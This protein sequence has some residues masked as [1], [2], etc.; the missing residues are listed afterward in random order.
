MKKL[1]PIFL[2]AGLLAGAIFLFGFLN[3]SAK[4]K[5]ALKTINSEE[6]IPD[7]RALYNALREHGKMLLVHAFDQE[8]DKELLQQLAKR[9]SYQRRARL[10]VVLVNEK[11]LSATDLTDNPIYYIGNHKDSPTLKRIASKLPINFSQDGFQFDNKDYH[12]SNTIFKLSLIPNP[13]NNRFPFYLITGNSNEAI[14]NYLSKT[15]SENGNSFSRNRWNYEVIADNQQLVFGNLNEQDWSLDKKTHFDFS[16]GHLVNVES[17]HFSLTSFCPRWNR[18]RLNRLL[19]N[20][21]ETLENIVAF[22]GKSAE[23]I[24]VQY[25]IFPNVENKGLRINN[26][27]Q[28]N[29]DFENNHVY[30]VANDNFSG[31]FL[32]MENELIIRKLM[33]Q[34]KQLALEKGFAVYFTKNWQ[35]EGFQYWAQRLFQ[36]QNLPPLKELMNNKL[37]REESDLVISCSAGMLVQ[38]LIEEWGKEKFIKKYATWIPEDKE[39]KSLEKAWIKYLKKLPQQTALTRNKDLPYLKGFNF[40]H[41]GY[42][43]YNG[44]GSQL[45]NESLTRLQKIGS[46]AV[47]IVPY[48]YMNSPNKPSF[49]PITESAGSENDEAVIFAHTRAQNLGMQTILKPQIWF[50]RGSWPGDVSMNSE[51]DWQAFFENYYRWMRHYAL[52]AEMYDFDALC[53]GVEFAKATLA[54]EAD[55]RALIKKLKGIYSGPVTYAANWGDEFENIKFWDALDYIGIDCYYPLSDQDTPSKAELDKNF[56]KV[57]AKIEK[58]SLKFQKPVIFT[59]IGFRSVDQTWL[60]PHEDARNRA[61]NEEAQKMCYEVVFENIKGKAWCNGLLWWKWPSYLDNRGK[62]NTRFTPYAKATEQTVEQW[63]AKLE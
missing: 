8:K 39:V 21:Q 5:V 4:P 53:I 55:W 44:Y 48:S 58:V 52:V 16:T 6:E 62:E 10:D 33:G 26:S 50:G 57:I 60:N 24:K 40:A 2:M 38:F 29:C 17:E 13:E 37:L 45:A 56:K 36:S 11:S 41:E 59:E 46:N 9:M 1:L 30:V 32:Q 28:A 54:R 35:E 3:A 14:I 19:M 15:L 51:A 31:H 23:G 18:N 63:F 34:P 47:A 22:T 42:S 7:R 43:I 20:C 49:I 61:F 12:S 25:S 27:Q